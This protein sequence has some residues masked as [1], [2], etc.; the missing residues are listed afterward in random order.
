M[1]IL[2]EIEDIYRNITGSTKTEPTNNTQQPQEEPKM[3]TFR[4]VLQAGV[5]KAEAEFAKVEALYSV[6][7]A[8]VSTVKADLA[9]LEADFSS[10][11][12]K[13]VTAV[14][15][16]F[17]RLEAHFVTPAPVE[18]APAPEVS[19]TPD[20]ATPTAPAAS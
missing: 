13:D 15:D 1:N 6:A 4:E 2:T 10:V 8:K 9:V 14:K 12:D 18:P 17:S 3:S 16:F 11:L 19:P 5:T 20:P 7:A